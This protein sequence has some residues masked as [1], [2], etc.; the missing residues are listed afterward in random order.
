MSTRGVAGDH[1]RARVAA[2]R[3]DVLT[4]PGQ[5]QLGVHVGV[6]ER[7]GRSEPVVGADHDPAVCGQPVEQR[8]CLAVLGTRV[9]VAAV[10]VNKHRRPVWARALPVEVQPLKSPSA[11]VRQIGYALHV[12][13]TSHERH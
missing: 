10:E 5:D 7:G 4:D 11:A 13:A 9:E 1:D 6:G 2:E 8:Q 12:S 3:R